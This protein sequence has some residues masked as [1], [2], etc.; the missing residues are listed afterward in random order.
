MSEKQPI[1]TYL[2]FPDFCLFVSPKEDPE[3]MI[4]MHVAYFGGEGKHK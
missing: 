2:S 3:E 4:H 1:V